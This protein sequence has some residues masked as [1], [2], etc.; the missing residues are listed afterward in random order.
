MKLL[1]G[2]VRIVEGD[3]KTPV[4]LP[5]PNRAR[6]TQLADF[7]CTLPPERFNYDD[8]VQKGGEKWM[9]DEDEKADPRAACGTT[10]CAA[11]WLPAIAPDDFEWAQEDGRVSLRCKNPAAETY[12]GLSWW[13]NISHDFVEAIFY[14][15]EDLFRL[16][17]GEKPARDEL[18]IEHL[19]FVLRLVAFTGATTEEELILAY[20]NWG[21]LSMK[22]K[23]RDQLQ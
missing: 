16:W 22:D 6:F 18:K 8:F 21:N 5:E 15:A 2:D 14:R 23:L 20:A 19:V 3:F 11:G 4:K 12:L 1:P 7:L 10:C 17:D 9:L 13:F